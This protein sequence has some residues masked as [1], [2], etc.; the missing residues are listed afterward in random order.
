MSKNKKKSSLFDKS[1]DR[2]P[3]FETDEYAKRDKPEPLKGMIKVTPKKDWHIKF[4]EFDIQ[5]KEGEEIEVP[6]M[7]EPTLKTEKVI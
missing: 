3:D 5:L 6:K 7:F 4:N 1:P 2:S